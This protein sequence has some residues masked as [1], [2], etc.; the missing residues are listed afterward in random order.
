MMGIRGIAVH[1]RHGSIV[2]CD[3]EDAQL[4]GLHASPAWRRETFRPSRREPCSRKDRDPARETGDEPSLLVD[5]DEE[6][7]DICACGAR[8]DSPCEPGHLGR[9]LHI[10]GNAVEDDTPEA[11]RFEAPGKFRRQGIPPEK[12]DHHLPYL[13]FHSHGNEEILHSGPRST[14]LPRQ[15]VEKKHSCEDRQEQYRR[16]NDEALPKEWT[17]MDTE[18]SSSSDSAV[19]PRPDGEKETN[20]IPR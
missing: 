20:G 4:P 12:A 6:R 1:V 13:F 14:R 2:P 9:A 7:Q 15:G 18:S 19:P 16:N 11:H 3:A 17:D 5:G 8:L 10:T